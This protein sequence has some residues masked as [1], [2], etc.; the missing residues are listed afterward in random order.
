MIRFSA[1]LYNIAW[2]FVSKDDDR[3]YLTGVLVEPH[4]KGG[5]LLVATDGHALIC[6]HDPSGSAEKQAIIKLK[7]V[8]GRKLASRSTIV[9]DGGS[10]TFERDGLPIDL[11]HDAEVDGKFPDWRRVVPQHGDP[12]GGSVIAP[13]LLARMARVGE[14]LRA[15]AMQIVFA[16][17]DGPG[18][19][20][21]RSVDHAFGV[22]MPMR[23][24]TFELPAFWRDDLK[25]R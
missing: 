5:V 23:Y 6:I 13:H 2:P 15:R 16:E 11:F 18:L 7:P 20:L 22:V 12:V 4:Q 24:E 19:V 25:A 3:P 9:V 14:R 21:W 10:A 8:G 17:E 1:D